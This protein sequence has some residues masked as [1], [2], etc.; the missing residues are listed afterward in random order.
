MSVRINISVPDE[1]HKAMQA[2]GGGTNW[3]A[4]AQAAF[5]L[6]LLPGAAEPQRQPVSRRALKALLAKLQQE[7]DSNSQR[8]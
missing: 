6:H 4:V 5:R 7:G 3:S 8:S 1:L 2:A